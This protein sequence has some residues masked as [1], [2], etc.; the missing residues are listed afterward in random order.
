MTI[1]TVLILIVTNLVLMG[2]GSEKE[3]TKIPEK[4]ILDQKREA[5]KKAKSVESTLM[6]ADKKR[7]VSLEQLVTPT[8]PE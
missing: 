3:K 5:I 2:C 1:K 4:N 6:N 8:H 7:K